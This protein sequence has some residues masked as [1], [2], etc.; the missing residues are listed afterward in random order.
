M[1]L[2]GPLTVDVADADGL[3]WA[4]EMVT[5]HHYLHAPVDV[6]SRPLAYLVQYH[7]WWGAGAAAGPRTIGILIF[8]RPEAT[9]CYQGK[10]TYGSGADV[11]SGR[12]RFDRWEVLNLA[13]VWFAPVV[14]PG[15]ALYREGAESLL[16]GFVDRRG[17]WRS[18]LASTVI[19]HV[20][21]LVR[22]DYLLRYP[23]CFLDEPYQLCA[24]LSYC[25][26]RLHKGTL[27][28]ASGFELARRNDAGIETWWTPLAPLDAATDAQVVTASQ[29]DRRAGNHRA[30]RQVAQLELPLV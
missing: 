11:A 8:G 25:D 7:Y 23:P 30:R 13:R 4:Q 28:R 26:T 24:L 21:D 2:T 12:A 3:A 27:Y 1:M 19:R 6:R 14:Q 17:V 29:R 22:R 20:L 18:T 5:K 10:L 9:R 15:G 16:P